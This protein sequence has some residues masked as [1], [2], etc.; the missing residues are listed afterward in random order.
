MEVVLSS[1]GLWRYVIAVVFVFG[2]RVE[3][4]IVVVARFCRAVLVVPHCSVDL[5]SGDHHTGF[6]SN[7]V[8]FI[9]IIHILIICYSERAVFLAFLESS[10]MFW[11]SHVNAAAL[12]AEV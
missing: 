5:A 7:L 4:S 10:K 12:L 6:V 8:S 11:R 2:L 9:T 1:A 3:C